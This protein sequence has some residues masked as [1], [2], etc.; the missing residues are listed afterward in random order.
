M[1]ELMC[2]ELTQVIVGSQVLV[3][4]NYEVE[5]DADVSEERAASIFR[6]EE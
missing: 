2:F 3:A 1:M 6:N 4:V 5:C